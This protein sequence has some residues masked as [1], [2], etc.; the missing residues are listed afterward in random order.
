MIISLNTEKMNELANLA[1]HFSSELSQACSCLTPVT[2]HDDWNCA[3]RDNINEVIHMTKKCAE[4]LTDCSQSFSSSVIK[5]ADS[6][7]QL[8][9]RNPQALMELQSALSKSLAMYTPS[10]FPGRIIGPGGVMPR[11]LELQGLDLDRINP[12]LLYP[13]KTWDKPISMIEIKYY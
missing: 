4:D 7:T 2:T 1:T 6:F 10:E 13:L 3:E 11:P 9:T 5:A 12:H 8:E